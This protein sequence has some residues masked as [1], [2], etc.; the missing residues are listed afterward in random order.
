MGAEAFRAERDF[1]Y[2]SDSW[3]ARVVLLHMLRLQRATV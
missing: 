1:K 2:T 3:G